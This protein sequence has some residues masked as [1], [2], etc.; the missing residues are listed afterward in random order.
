MMKK[1][2]AVMAAGMTLCGIGSMNVHAVTDEQLEEIRAAMLAEVWNGMTTEER[3]RGIENSLIAANEYVMIGEFL[4]EYRDGHYGYTLD[5]ID[6]NKTNDVARICG[7]YGEWWAYDSKYAGESYYKADDG[8]EI[9]TRADGKTFAI[10]EQD[11]AWVYVDEN[12]SEAERY[13]RLTAFT[14]LNASFYDS[15]DVVYTPIETEKTVEIGTVV[16]AENQPVY[17]EAVST[18]AVVVYTT[19]PATETAKVTEAKKSG[20]AGYFAAG[21]AAAAAGAGAFFLLKNKKQK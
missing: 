4:A 16:Y 2:M 17:T 21:F 18:T 1:M 6:V 14:Y 20:H 19:A 11:D 8:T 10:M 3:A 12:G 9:V 13:E 15:T 5:S 7:E